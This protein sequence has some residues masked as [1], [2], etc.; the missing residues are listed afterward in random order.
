[1][2]EELQAGRASSAMD[3]GGL[4]SPHWETE[5]PALSRTPCR[6][7]L[8]KRTRT[9]PGITTRAEAAVFVPTC[10][11]LRSNHERDLPT[12]IEEALPDESKVAEARKRLE[13]AGVKYVMSCWIDLLGVPK[14]KPVPLSQWET[15]CRG[16]GPQFAGALHFLRSRSGAGGSGSGADS[17]RRLPVPLP[18]EAGTRLRVFGPLHA[19]GPL[20]RLSAPRP[21]ATG[22]GGSGSRLSVFRGRGARVHGDALR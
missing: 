14:T 9:R 7:T 22:R 13:A 21:Q 1:M 15:I 16:K 20:R 6:R 2:V 8:Q 3:D 17:R 12:S 5:R 4:L 11:K 18:M 19:D 10:P